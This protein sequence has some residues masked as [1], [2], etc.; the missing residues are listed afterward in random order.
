MTSIEYKI[1]MTTF[2]GETTWYCRRPVRMIIQW[3]AIY[4]QCL[5]WVCGSDVGK[6]KGKLSHDGAANYSRKSY[7]TPRP[8]LIEKEIQELRAREEELR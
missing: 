1:G 4:L 2:S 5:H 8:S 6:V 7:S 3:R